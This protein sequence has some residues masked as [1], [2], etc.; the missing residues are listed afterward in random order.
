MTSRGAGFA[1]GLNWIF[2]IVFAVISSLLFENQQKFTYLGLS[3]FWCI[4]I[5]F[6]L[7]FV[8]ETQ[9]LSPYKCRKLYFPPVTNNNLET[10]QDDD[11]SSNQDKIR[12]SYN[13]IILISN[14]K[15]SF[16]I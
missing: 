3:L 15:N 8:R 12:V 13:F 11:E 10:E 6:I 5:F 2:V 14:N 4:G 7:H 1:F 9:G 16:N